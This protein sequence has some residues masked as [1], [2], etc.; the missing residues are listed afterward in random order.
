MFNFFRG[1][2]KNVTQENSSVANKARM[3]FENLELA[4]LLTF[5]LQLRFLNKSFFFVLEV[6]IEI[7]VVHRREFQ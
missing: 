3:R 2:K 7:L 5:Y 1:L 6:F 4:W